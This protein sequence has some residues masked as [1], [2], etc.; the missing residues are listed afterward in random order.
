[1]TGRRPSRNKSSCLLLPLNSKNPLAPPDARGAGAHRLENGPGLDRLQERVEL[2]AGARE[3]D[4]IALV[5]DVEDTAAEDVREP[6]HLVAVLAR[7]AH[8][9]EHQLALDVIAIGKI[10]DLDDFYQ[11]VQLLG[12]LLD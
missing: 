2:L 9:D 10:D 6:L 1:M 8:L 7:G 4:G 12:D 3:L 5:G 11:L